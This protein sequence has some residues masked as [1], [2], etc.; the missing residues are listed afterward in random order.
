MPPF[1]PLLASVCLASSVLGAPAFSIHS[2]STRDWVKRHGEGNDSL[3][4][5]LEFIDSRTSTHVKSAQISYSRTVDDSSFLVLSPA[6]FLDTAIDWRVRITSPETP[7]FSDTAVL[8][9]H[10]GA[11]KCDSPN[12]SVDEF[13]FE[14][15][16][17]WLEP[18][19]V[20]PID[21]TYN[22]PEQVRRLSY[23]GYGTSA[24]PV[25]AL[26]GST[27]L[28]AL[29]DRMVHKVRIE[30]SYGILSYSELWEGFWHTE[31]TIDIKDGIGI[32]SW[33]A[34]GNLWTLASSDGTPIPQTR[35]G[36]D[37]P[38]KKGESWVYKDSSRKQ[39]GTVGN[40]PT[41]L[42][43]LELLDTP[44]DSAGWTCLKVRETTAPDTGK[45][46][47]STLEIRLDT[48]RQIVRVL[49]GSR[50]YAGTPWSMP[51]TMEGK[52]AVGLLTFPMFS[53]TSN[54]HYR[55]VSGEAHGEMPMTTS[56]DSF[57]M[58]IQHGIGSTGIF[59][60][61]TTN[62]FAIFNSFSIWKLVAYA[63]E[64]LILP[65]SARAPRPVRDIAW[66]R[67]RLARDPAMEVVR[68]RM[69]GV[70]TR[71]KGL[72]ALELLD[73][74]GIGFVQVRDGQELATLRVVRP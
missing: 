34:H 60:N 46:T 12:V 35:R 4:Y 68:I 62:A 5:H 38:L 24:D 71:A 11:A 31:P 19:E 53:D 49:K 1:L 40:A 14:K 52:W 45:R 67:A 54:L 28:A 72:K 7:S 41:S 42:I 43:S 36:L 73:A 74:R 13:R 30:S 16:A 58:S 69:D 15:L 55:E 25:Y 9:I 2:G 27:E 44:T 18:S 33:M 37:H 3:R 23:Y 70:R 22:D 57:D 51:S 20:F 65:A 26:T 8:R 56:Q 48:L 64:N 32:T 59:V 50:E 63:T 47:D 17:Y 39:F 66:L 21:L 61:S 10:S 6:N 29:N